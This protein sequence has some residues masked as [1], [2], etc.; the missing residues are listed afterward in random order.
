MEFAAPGIGSEW[1]HVLCRSVSGSRDCFWNGVLMKSDTPP[2][3]QSMPNNFR[4]G[5][6]HFGEKFDGYIDD[7]AI[8]D[9]SLS[10]DEVLQ[11]VVGDYAST[12]QPHGVRICLSAPSTAQSRTGITILSTSVDVAVG[13]VFEAT[14]TCA[15][16]SKIGFFVGSTGKSDVGTAFAFNCADQT[17]EFGAISGSGPFSPAATFDKKLNFS[18]A[19]DVHLRLLLRAAASGAGMAEFYA[20]DVLSHPYTFG[21]IASSASNPMGTVGIIDMSNTN[22]I[23]M[24]SVKGWRMTLP[25]V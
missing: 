1:G 10:D 18:V 2:T 19:D 21:A 24:S 6:T 9:R 16:R 3:H 13:A 17:F 20:N 4:I 22:S 11:A 23:D 7:V 25:A 12:N 5:S 8:F 15:N 14:V